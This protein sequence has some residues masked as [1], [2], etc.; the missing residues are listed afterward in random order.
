M[1]PG[2][3]QGRKSKRAHGRGRGP[4]S[5]PSGR[6]FI[7]RLEGIAHGGEALGRHEGKVVFVPYT[8]PGEEVRVRLIREKSRWAR[9][10]LLNIVTPSPDR[11]EP[12]CP[13]FG[14]DGCG[15][16][17]WQHISY[18][19]QLAL[20]REIVID[21][22]RRLGHI[23][24]PSVKEVLAVGDPF[25]YRNHMQ[26]TVASGGRL[27]LL[28]A[29]SHRVI[30]VDACLLLHP[31]LTELYETLDL[32][33]EGLRRVILRAGV[34]TGERLIILETDGEEMPE[35]E[36]D[37]PVSVVLHRP[38][39]PPFPLAGV[40]FFHERVG[41]LTFRISSGSFFQVNTAGAEVLVDLVRRYL[42]PKGHETLLDLYSGVGLF[43]LSLAS[44]V[45]LVFGIE[46]DESAME[47]AAFNVE[48]LGLENVALH[49]GPVEEVLRAL[50]EPA[51]LAILDPPR[52]G[53]GQEVIA[54]L[55]RLRVRRLVYV[56]CDPATLARDVVHLQAQ[57]YHLLDLQPVDMFPQ[58]YHIETVSVWER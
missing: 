43:G 12:P 29:E 18:E 58:T 11:V 2:N 15:G 25:H 9:A 3:R 4:R 31:L 28:R 17:Q 36:V 42:A 27:G 41:E 19:R 8:I 16:C 22:L 46:A 40:P 35:L 55:R 48:A 30:P 23:E 54:Q 53:A 49:E 45:G 52:S 26:F 44:Q 50:W 20:K 5:I 39:H 57:G 34:H 10:Q 7:L 6:E 24:N 32:Q 14:P 47:D 56:S 1:A 37:I 51:D 33:W 21:Q 13:F 38:Q